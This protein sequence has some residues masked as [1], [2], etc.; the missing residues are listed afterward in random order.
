MEDRSKCSESTLGSIRFGC[1]TTTVKRLVR[2]S[3]TGTALRGPTG[4]PSVV[5]SPIDRDHMR[6]DSTFQKSHDLGDAQRRQLHGRVRRQPV[7][8]LPMGSFSF[9][10]ERYG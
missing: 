8:G 10:G 1:H 6:A 3:R 4:C 5:P 2:G 7:Y 9:A